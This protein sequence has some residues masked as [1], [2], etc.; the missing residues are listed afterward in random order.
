MDNTKLEILLSVIAHG[1]ITRAGEELGYTQSGVSHLIKGLERELGFPLLIRGRSGVLP[2]ADCQR[3]LPAMRQ[4]VHWN[5]QLDSLASDVRGIVTGK[6]RIG[7]FTSISV[8]WLPQIIH[9][10]QQRYPHME[11]ELVEGGDQALAASIE[12]GLIDI[13]FG[14]RPADIPADWLPLLDDQLMAVL[15]PDSFSGAAF[16]LQGFHQSPFIALPASFDREVHDIFQSHGILPDIKF[17]ST[18]DYTIISMV[19]QG[20][21]SSVLPEMVLRGYRHCRIQTL[22]LQPAC[23]RQLGIAVPSLKNA[24][25]A[26]LRFIDCVHEVIA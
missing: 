7:S 9:V 25:P 23:R 5:A 6:L 4:I 2:T 1:S 19:E 18:D 16:P 12:D 22:P 10:F 26:A 8:H 14:R 3:L 15:P 20:L 21:G 13:G 11:I 17:S 24:S